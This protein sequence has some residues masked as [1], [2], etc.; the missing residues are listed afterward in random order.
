MRS[1]AAFFAV[2]MVAVA[3]IVFVMSAVWSEPVPRTAIEAGA[4]VA[5]V[6]QMFS[7]AVARSSAPANTLVGWGIGMFLRLVVLVGWGFVAPRA[8][9]LPLLPAMLSLATCFFV[10]TVVEPIFLKA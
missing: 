7:F 6:T 2:S 8:L 5:L 1:F 3:V 10:T 9:G 4:G